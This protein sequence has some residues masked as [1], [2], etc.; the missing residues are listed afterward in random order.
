MRRIVK[1]QKITVLEMQFK[2]SF[3]VLTSFITTS[4]LEMSQKSRFMFM[5]TIGMFG[6]KS[7]FQKRKAIA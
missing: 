5:L 6:K 1:H 4:Q 2:L 7:G 3:K